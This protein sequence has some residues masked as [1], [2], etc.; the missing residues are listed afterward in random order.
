MSRNVLTLLAALLALALAS[1][2]AAPASRS[3]TTA[4][5]AVVVQDGTQLALRGGRGFGYGRS[6]YGYRPSSRYPGYRYPRRRGHGFLHGL[7]AG[8]LLSHFFGGGYG[9][10][11][12]PFFLLF[13]LWMLSRRR[14][15]RDYYGGPAPRW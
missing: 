15:R 6:R 12:W 10:P 8:W 7:F 2:V 13:V 3:A 4:A 5:A 9:F 11:L 14:R 1:P